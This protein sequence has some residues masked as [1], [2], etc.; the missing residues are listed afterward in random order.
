MKELGIINRDK[1]A[2]V[3]IDIQDKFK[4]VINEIDKV[5]KNTNIL[6]KAAEILK[7]PLVVTE[8]YPKGL[9][10]ILKEIQLPQ[11]QQIF[12]KIEFS[13]F[14][15]KNF[16][17]KIEGLQVNTLVIFGIESHVCVVQTV[18]DALKQGYEVHVVEDAISSRTL[19]NKN[20]GIERMRQS[21]AFIVSTEMILFQLMKKAFVEGFKEISNL[22]K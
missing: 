13:C 21:G 16:T 19:E 15:C 1:T 18:L 12:D 11:N 10:K 9:G 3:M 7:I 4:P 2:F 22:L 5:I 14:G 17:D 20:I 6:I 8:Q